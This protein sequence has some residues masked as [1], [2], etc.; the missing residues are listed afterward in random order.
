MKKFFYHIPFFAAIAFAF[1]SCTEQIEQDVYTHE[2]KVSLVK[3]EET[4]TAVV[5]GQS[6]ASYVWTTGDESYLHV[7][8]NGKEGTITNISYSNDMA[9]ATLTV[10]FNETATA[11]YTYTAKYYKEASE[12]G[13]PLVLA[14]QSPKT[15]SFDPAA[16]IMVS[17]EISSDDTRLTSLQFTMGRVVSVNKMILTGL[18]SGEKVATVVFELADGYMVAR[19]MVDKNSF[20]NSGKKL[21]FN[22]NNVPVAENGSFPVYFISA[23]VD[24]ASIKDVIVTTDKHVYTKSSTLDPNPFEGK[25]ISFAAGTMKRFTMAMGEYGEAISSGTAYTLVESIDALYDGA[26]YLIYGDGFVLGEQKTNNRA[27]VA[28]S[29]NNGTITIDNTIDAYPVVIESVSG[30]Y[31]IKDIKNNGYLYNNATD[32]NYLKNKAEKGEYT[33]WTI[34]ISNGTAS[35]NNV[36]NTARGIM[37]FNPN[38]GSPLFAAYG[39]IPNGG[40]SNLALYVDVTTCVELADPNLSF[41]GEATIN[42]NWADIAAFT[43]PTLNNPHSVEV[44]YSS[45]NTDVATVDSATGE[46]EFVGDGTAV[47]TA[48]STKT[49]EYKSGSAQYTLVVSGAPV[50]YDFTTVAELNSLVSSTSKNYSGVLTNAVVSFVPATNT[51]I[52]KDATGSIMYYKKDHVLLQGQTFSGEL[53]VA[54]LKYNNLYSEITSFLEGGE[55]TGSGTEVAPESVTLAQLSGEYDAWQN[56]YVQ[57]SNL[58][59]VSKSDKNINVTDGTNTYVVYDNTGNI[60]VNPNDVITAKG[61]ITKYG[62]TEELKVWAATDLTKESSAVATPEITCSSNTVTIT[63]TTEGATIYYTIDGTNPTTASDVYSAPFAITE[64]VTVKAIAVKSGQA[65]SGIVSETCVFSSGSAP[66]PETITFANLNLSNDTQY[67]DPFDGGNFTITFA[68]GANDGKYY[69]T[70]S[71]IRTYGNG[72]ITIASANYKIASIKFTWSGSYAPEADVATPSGYS[73][74]TKTW[75]GSAYSVVLTRPS[76]S[77]H[78]RLQ[79]VTVTYE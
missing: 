24:N 14:N 47:I 30:G 59:V 60:S 41:K 57:I 2:V 23:P 28:V 71:G 78:W 56:A 54:A 40:T 45:S 55:F 17:K 4:K 67:S 35:I 15:D 77:G 52:I 74:E 51:A 1:A 8:E 79:A 70:G 22:Y 66:D 73:T 12:A 49:P 29:E 36:D 69:T 63:C 3:S 13:N 58:T 44:T 43:A 42:V 18:E 5:E 37:G 26:T 33:T 65:N 10:S 7:F 9:V 25:T 31:A 38:N 16:D 50:N 53:T 76:G 11:P 32:K 68:G 6:S 62:S 61:T 20:S 64:T 27:A 21:S 75:T 72:S 34:S 48:T 46:I 39:T 19:Y